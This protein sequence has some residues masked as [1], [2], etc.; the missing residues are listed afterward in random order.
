M[1]S[2]P[3][4][5]LMV[6]QQ[7]RH[8][9]RPAVFRPIR[10]RRR[11]A[12]VFAVGVLVFLRL[13]TDDGSAFAQR[14]V[15][16]SPQ[17]SELTQRLFLELAAIGYAGALRTDLAVNVS[18]EQ[19]V[20]LTRIQ[21]GF[22]VRLGATNRNT[23]IWV[24][25]RESNDTIWRARLS[26]GNG[27]P[28]TAAVSAAESLR[29]RLLK[30]YGPGLAPKDSSSNPSDI[31]TVKDVPDAA[32]AK[33]WYVSAGFGAQGA[34]GG[35]GA[36]GLAR[37]SVGRWVGERV[38]IAVHA[39]APLVPASFGATQGDVSVVPMQLVAGADYAF[40][41]RDSRWIPYVGAGI[42]ISMLYV[43]G[44]ALPPNVSASDFVVTGIAAGQ[45]GVAFRLSERFA[46]LA[47]AV[48]GLHFER[49]VFEIA[50]NSNV[51]EW[52][53]PLV[54]GDIGLEVRF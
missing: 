32:S 48:I 19:V 44:T 1:L 11:A 18:A 8:K 29:G 40:L 4:R 22:I 27:D 52:G 28:R 38:R 2:S 23:E 12:F 47:Q 49:A 30:I 42:G 6:A 31:S 51:A 50:G 39:L 26:V 35:I 3:N 16:V 36:G 7:T 21:Q 45:T 15:I 10:R 43:S 20:S 33:Q 5:S 14:A 41:K 9:I 13:G 17:E 53:I 37:L 24:F 34:P 54:G 46:L 25:V